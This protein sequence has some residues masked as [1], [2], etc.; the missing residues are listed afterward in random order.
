MTPF[1]WVGAEI[2]WII[3]RGVLAVAETLGH[4]KALYNRVNLDVRKA[5]GINVE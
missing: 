4:D 2:T 3:E 1:W 5:N